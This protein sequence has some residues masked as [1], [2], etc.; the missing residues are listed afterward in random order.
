MKKIFSQIDGPC[1]VF[2]SLDPDVSDRWQTIALSLGLT[3]GFIT[4]L[5]C[6]NYTKIDIVLSMLTAASE[7]LEPR[8][9][10]DVFAMSL[11]ANQCYSTLDCLQTT[12]FSPFEIPDSLNEHTLAW[13]SKNSE[14]ISQSL[15]LG[16]YMGLARGQLDHITYRAS[17][18]EEKAYLIIQA[19][20]N[21]DLGIFRQALEACRI[22]GVYDRL[23][24]RS[25]PPTVFRLYH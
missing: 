13:L 1:L 22:K 8:A 15:L 11:L 21:G 7:A 19:G 17:N 5:T 20:S 4:E 18:C 16:T 3:R 10:I 9:R 25:T 24:P 2:L 12:T 6:N 14:I 23:T